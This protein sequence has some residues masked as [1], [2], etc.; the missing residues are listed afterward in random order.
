MRSR[1]VDRNHAIAA[2]VECP[3][4]WAEMRFVI[5]T[6]PVWF[7][8]VAAIPNLLDLAPVISFPAHDE[9]MVLRVPFKR[10][11]LQKTRNEPSG[12]TSGSLNRIK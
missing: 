7:L 2:E 11:A 6:E 9:E 3:V 1:K 4:I 5:R 12:A 8:F 10:P